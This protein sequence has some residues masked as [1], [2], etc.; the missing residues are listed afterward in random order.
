MN[1]YKVRENKVKGHISASSRASW[2]E[3]CPAFELSRDSSGVIFMNVEAVSVILKEGALI[4]TR[5][6]GNLSWRGNIVYK[7]EG[8]TVYVALLDS[9]LDDAVSPGR[10][11]SIK[12]I[13]QYFIYI[14]EGVVIKV[15]PTYPA[16]IAARVT[17][18]EEVINSR[19]SPRY[20]VHLSADM[21]PVWDS[22]SYAA[23]VTDISYGGIAFICGSRF[24]YNE[25][26]DTDI[27]LYGNQVIKVRGKIIRKSKKNKV[28]EY[29]MQ[30]S[31][32]D[33][34]SYNKLSLFFSQLEENADLM[35]KRFLADIKG[36]SH[37]F[38]C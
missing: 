10:P 1:C 31:D 14:F 8:R 9:Y 28:S 11:I 34:G 6:D 23:T 22:D 29:S 36:K 38:S 15:D 21:K 35:Y 2:P 20:D 5:L 30:F 37:H 7:S 16:Y 25:E 12:Y 19:L 24:D 17:S 32:M 18:A 4:G 3:M 13:N 33:E 27:R 26:L